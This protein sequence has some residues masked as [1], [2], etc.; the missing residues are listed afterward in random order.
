VHQV[1]NQYIVAQCLNHYA[2]PGPMY[3][4]VC[5][6]LRIYVFMYVCVCVILY[7]LLLQTTILSV[8]WQRLYIRSC[9]LSLGK[10][11]PLVTAV[12]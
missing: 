8:W 9:C 6:Y 5:M 10:L 2:T 11:D 7:G 1:G 3:V 12:L 4:Y